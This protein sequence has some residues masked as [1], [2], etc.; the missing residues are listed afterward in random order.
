MG[1]TMKRIQILGTGCPSCQ[2]L[3]ENAESAASEL[4]IEFEITKVTEID[5][6]IEFGVMA[7]PALVVDGD[8]KA[9]GRV[10]S[11]A[12]IRTILE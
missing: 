9:S 11:S 10:L 8:V 7:T 6:I 4:G 2:R 3:A 1:H 5:R 12:E